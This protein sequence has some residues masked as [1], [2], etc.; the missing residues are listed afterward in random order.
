MVDQPG[1][2]YTFVSNIGCTRGEVRIFE[3]LPAYRVKTNLLTQERIRI[4]KVLTGCENRKLVVKC[5]NV[6]EQSENECGSL[7]IG[8]A[9]Q[10]FF[11]N[12]NV[13]DVLYLVE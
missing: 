8:L 1:Y 2:H 11:A 3:T 12:K 7:C 9:H 6:A 4:L 10:F 13:F 5:V